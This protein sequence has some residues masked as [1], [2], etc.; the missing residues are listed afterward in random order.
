MK[1]SE[2]L[3]KKQFDDPQD[4]LSIIPE[5]S[6]LLFDFQ[7]AIVRWALR[8]GRAAIFADCGMGKTAMQL[9]WA[10]CIPGRVL[11]A[12]PLAVSG[13]TEKE[14][15][16]FGI[17][18]KYLRQD[19]KKTQIVITNYE[20]LE[21]FNPDDFDGVVLDESSILKSYTGKIR[22]FIIEQWGKVKFRLAATATPAPNDYME[23]GN[24]AEFL[25][26]MTTPEMLSMFFV[27]DGG[28]TQKW[29]LKG[30]AEDDFWK[31]ICNWAVM[32]R[33]PS[34]LGF[35]DGNFVLP[36]C[37]IRDII[38]RDQSWSDDMLF[39]LQAATL[40]ERLDARRRTIKERVKKCSDLANASNQPRLIWCNLNSESEAIKKAVKDAVEVKGSDSFE[41]KED[42][43][44]GFSE[45]RY[46][47]LVTK[48]S[49]AGFGMNWQH[50]NEMDF[51]GLSDSY[52]QF[53]QSIRR[54]WRFGQK[55][56]VFANVITADTEG[57]V[58]AN[59][60]RK[61]KES[62][63]MAEKMVKHMKDISSSEIRGTVK[64]VNKYQPKQQIKL[65]SF[66]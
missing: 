25:G 46:R 55:R 10:K 43:L 31:W 4:G 32:I 40:I 19:D 53:Y 11:I 22:T 48:A 59:I 8:R 60:K 5:L 49:I 1:Y 44:I 9:E 35:D 15:V 17:P 14:G 30:H 57:A 42:R 2:F 23:L 52:E 18:V 54:C 12:A 61:E 64:S 20:M 38:V 6:P 63:I 16:K 34:D 56:E 51:V 13:Q 39:P 7:K 28:E 26:S 24:H 37:H 27:H 58:T 33:K 21:Y 66:L 41:V 36:S 65:P 50:C 45:G 47:V 29:R 3:S 62:S